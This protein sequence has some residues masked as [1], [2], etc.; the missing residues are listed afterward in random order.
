MKWK[1]FQGKEIST[2]TADHQHLSNVLWYLKIFWPDLYPAHIREEVIKA[3]K[4]RFNGQILPYR[5]HLD[6]EVEI[7]GLKE[8]GLLF[9]NDD[10]THYIVFEGRIIG[11]LRPPEM[12]DHKPQV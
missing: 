1:N 11:D 8:R 6:F 12:I 4:D 10:G 7:Q 9:E 5:P 2:E 3:I